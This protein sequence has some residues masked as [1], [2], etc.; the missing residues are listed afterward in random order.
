MGW[1]N[2]RRIRAAQES[3]PVPEEKVP[4]VLEAEGLAP[5]PRRG[6]L[7]ARAGDHGGAQLGAGAR[8]PWNRS[9]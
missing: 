1:S 3:L 9:R 5:G 8:T 6:R 7:P 4:G 2:T